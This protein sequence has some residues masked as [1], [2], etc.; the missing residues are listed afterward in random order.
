[1]KILY[2]IQATGNGH[3]SRAREIIPH[4]L[5]YGEV[6]IL[7]SGTQADVSLP[8]LVKYKKKGISYTFGK[9]GGV[10]IIDSIRQFKPIR[11]LADA[12]A[13]PVHNYNLVINDFEPVS[14]W[15]CKMK[16]KPCIALSHQ[17]AFLSHKTP[18]PEK[19]DL[20]AEAVF[21]SYAPVSHQYAFHFRNYDS[22]IYTPVIR[23]EIREQRIENK[24][25]ITVY[26]PAHGD[27]MLI[28]H[29][30][31]IK[32]V[33]WQVFSKHSV[34]EYRIKNVEVRPITNESFIKS[35]AK[36]NGLVTAG[37]FEGPAEAMFLGKKVLSVPMNNQ[38]EQLCNAEA[39][40]MMGV[41]VVKEIDHRFAEKLKS[42]LMFS[43]APRVS[44]PDMT[45]GIVD[46]LMQEHAQTNMAWV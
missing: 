24:E 7:V 35:L 5:N 32:E 16:N 1:M 20:F 27:N 30:N 46:E 17:S 8:Y 38:Y 43:E 40:K 44:F 37:G 29:F 9:R 4:L 36:G 22:F 21:K 23:K 25:H 15:A 45:A 6:D 12:V 10:D 2:A 34:K 18:R 28:K 31:E 33:E 39:M 11:F 14:A 13:F 19:K 26:L 3:L 42:W 41:K